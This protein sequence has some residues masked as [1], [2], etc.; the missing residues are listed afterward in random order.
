MRNLLKFIFG[1]AKPTRK[2]TRVS[3]V[4]ADAKLYGWGYPSD[5]GFSSQTITLNPFGDYVGAVEK[6]L[7]CDS[8]GVVLNRS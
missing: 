4:F 8:V 3:F 1:H 7:L 6:A 5:L 2:L